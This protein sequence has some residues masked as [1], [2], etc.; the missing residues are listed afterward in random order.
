M[1]KY[2]KIF[3]TLMLVM[4]VTVLAGCSAA[5]NGYFDTAKEISNL[6]QYAFDGKVEVKLNF[7]DMI[8]QSQMTEDEL[9]ALDMLQKL[10]IA[11]EGQY[12]A[13]ESAYYMDMDLGMGEYTIPMKCYMTSD[14]MLIDANSFVETLKAMGADQ[15]EIDATK[16]AIGSVKWIDVLDMEGVMGN[17]LNNKDIFSMSTAIYDVLAY[18]KD[19]SFKNYDPGCFSGN[20]SQGYTLTINDNNFK[21]VFNSLVQYSKDN[22]D[23]IKADINKQKNNIDNSI[24][25]MIGID[26]SYLQQTLDSIKNNNDANNLNAIADEITAMFKG[27]NLTST[28]KKVGNGKYTEVDKGVIVINDLTDENTSLSLTINSTMN[29]DANKDV[30]IN[31]PTTDISTLD[32]IAAGLKPSVIEGT[33]YMNDNQI[34][35]TKTYDASMFNTYDI[36]ES[37][38]IL[39]NNFNYFPMRQIAEMFGENVVWDKATGEI[40]VS[41]DGKKI[42]MS[43]FIKDNRTYVKLRDFEKLGYQ[44]DYYKDADLG[45]IATFK[46]EVK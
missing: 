24:F 37:Q 22:Y 9:A 10:S 28:I 30:N 17:L 2:A 25:A 36:V 42:D 23:A 21:T 26:S 14:T 12:D 43:G 1:K 15:A 32:K 6:G 29:C 20:S 13:K 35:L 40:Y 16:A 31:V 34:H 8:D 7:N 5:G 11:Y 33:F 38:A 19:N 39:R 18:F 4:A 3:L 41:R 46:Y 45:G 44:I 27:T